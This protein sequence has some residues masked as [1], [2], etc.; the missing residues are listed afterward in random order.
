MLLVISV[1]EFESKLEGGAETPSLEIKAACDWNVDSLAK[2]ILAM[3]NVR[4]GGYIIV[5]V[6]DGSFARQG[7]SATQ[8]ETYNLDTMRDQ[9]A[10]FA[11]PHVTF[12]V[13]FPRDSSNR[14]YAV[15]RVYPFEELPVICIKESRDTKRGVIYYRNSDVRVQSAAVSNSYD[16][17]DIIA[18]AAVKMVH[19]FAKQ[20]L[21][22]QSQPSIEDQAREAFKVEREDL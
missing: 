18:N 15:I 4:D 3:S 12:T 22:I 16:M 6:A 10:P 8:K 13:E 19:S 17:R 14:E 11:D 21:T 9:M 20:G 2:D 5:G 7:I 1:E